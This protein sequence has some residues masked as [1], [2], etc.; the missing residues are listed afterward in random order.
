M[1]ELAWAEAIKGALPYLER[2]YLL[3][4][5][6]EAERLRRQRELEDYILTQQMKAYAPETLWTPK[7]P[8]IADYLT[9]V[10]QQ[11]PVYDVVPRELRRITPEEYGQVIKA[12]V[13]GQPSPIPLEYR[14]EEMTPYQRAQVELAKERIGLQRE[15][16]AKSVEFREKAQKHGVSP[17][18]ISLLRLMSGAQKLAEG[19][20]LAGDV[21]LQEQYNLEAQRYFKEAQE[22]FKLEKPEA[23]KFII[24]QTTEMIPATWWRP[25]KEVIKREIVPKERQIPRQRTLPG[26]E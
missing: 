7:T 13:R 16:W 24:E 19:A 3:E 2:A 6:R 12:V 22:Q 21:D 11:R 15:K 20:M 17:T 25:A 26:L 18:M 5:E 8:T 1:A 23:Q 4:R 14:R 9:A 10:R